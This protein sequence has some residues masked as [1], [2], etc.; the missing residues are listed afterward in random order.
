MQDSHG[1]GVGLESMRRRAAE[2]GGRVSFEL[3]HPHGTLV[4]VQLPLESR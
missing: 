1:V 2:I 4:T 3:A